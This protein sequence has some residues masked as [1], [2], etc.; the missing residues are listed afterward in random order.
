METLSQT[1]KERINNPII[2]NMGSKKPIRDQQVKSIANKSE[3]VQHEPSKIVVTYNHKVRTKESARVVTLQTVLDEIKSSNSLKAKIVKVRSIQHRTER[4]KIKKE[5]LPWFS[6]QR[7]KGNVRKNSQY[8]VTKFIIADADHVKDLVGLRKKVNE[9]P[10]LMMSMVSPSG[11]GLKLGFALS[12][13]V[14]TEQEYRT[15]FSYVT[16]TYGKKYGI[17]FD[18]VDDPAR[19][20]YLSY[21]PEVYFNSESLCLDVEHIL[22]NYKI[23][24]KKTKKKSQVP[25]A[26]KGTKEGGRSSAAAIL[27][28]DMNK[29]G[30]RKT[31][32][33]ELL[34]GW[35]MRKNTPPLD[36]KELLNQ[37]E[38]MYKLYED[39]AKINP[40]Q[41][42]V[43]D[44]QYYRI[45]HR[46]DNRTVSKL[47]N[48]VIQPKELLVLEGN[49]C[50]KCSVSTSAGHLYKEVILENTDWHSKTKLLKAIGHQDCSFYGSENDVQF[51]CEYVNGQTPV[52]KQGTH[53]IGLIENTWVIKNANITVSGVSPEQSII[54]YEK[55]GDS[56]LQ[57][58]VYEAVEDVDYRNILE[59]FYAS[60]LSINKH[61]VI[62]PILGWMFTVPVKS[63]I[64]EYYGDYPLLF[65]QGTQGG[66]KTSTMELFMKLFGYSEAKPYSSDLKP[67]PLLKLLSSTN[68]IPVF[69]DEFKM[70]DMDGNIVDNLLRVMRKSYDGQLETKGQADQTV[71][72]YQLLAP[73]ALMGEWSISQPA[74]KERILFPRFSDEV[75]KNPDMQQAF[76]NVNDLPLRGFMPRYLQYILGQ[77]IKTMYTQA[78]E[79]V[80]KH[81]S[82]KTVAPRVKHNLSVLVMGVRL[83]EEFGKSN[84]IEV[85]AIELGSVLDS[86]LSEITGS[87]TGLVKSSVDQ[88][89]EELGVLAQKQERDRE[90]LQGSADSVL[91]FKTGEYK[92]SSKTISSLSIRFTKIYPDYSEHMKRS[93]YKGDLVDKD[94]YQK[95]MKEC[96]YILSVSHPVKYGPTHQRAVI[97][98]IDAAQKQG[99]NLTGFGIEDKVNGTDVEEVTS[100]T[101][102]YNADVTG[103]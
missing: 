47:T 6:F 86:Q 52:R 85:P 61:A 22:K 98:D 101:G 100:V 56:F 95:L 2:K 12:R 58:I 91:W 30:V 68:G 92:Q 54:P 27:I 7:F 14:T 17:E 55:G 24:T 62:V 35:N 71:R 57:G 38:Y 46:G 4:Q 73:I 44:G 26:I 48:F 5:T 21:D 79:Y 89:I 97:I 33:I 15:I 96:P 80:K 76:R 102:S 9:D 78:A 67:F 34:L 39:Q 25:V 43:Q 72:E 11:D 10:T 84:N 36:E 60:I 74:I 3:N 42:D 28:G 83:F 99:I 45:T 75:K 59:K 31:V 63:K 29:R 18:Q 51:L 53:I 77:D 32:A 66:G 16:K 8:L 103:F 90:F 64:Q 81:F 1:N 20:C 82:K 87:D 37:I 49:D 13:E 94:S 40:I 50:M 41:I 69:L 93:G 23:E 88:L 65:V 70:A 19:V